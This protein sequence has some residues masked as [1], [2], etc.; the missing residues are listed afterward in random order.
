MLDHDDIRN[1]ARELSNDR[2]VRRASPEWGMIAARRRR[3]ALERLVESGL[4]AELTDSAKRGAAIAI[5][6]AAAGG[7]GG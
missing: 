4:G 2:C 3:A 7:G 5:A 6:I 1:A